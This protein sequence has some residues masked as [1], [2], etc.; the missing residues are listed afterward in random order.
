MNRTIKSALSA[1]ALASVLALQACGSSSGNDGSAGN[2]PPAETPPVEP[3]PVE[4]PPVE[5]P[6]VEPP[7]PEPPAATGLFRSEESTAQFLTRATFGPSEAD[8]QDLTGTEASEW[9]LDQFAAEP[10][11]M[12]P[13]MQQFQ[14][15][16]TI[17]IP[18]AN[19]MN[20]A[21]T[22]FAFWRN[23]LEGEDQLRQRMILA[24]SEILVISAG[25]SDLLRNIPEGTAMHADIL[26]EHA[27]GNY[28]DL[29]EDITYS[30]GMGHFLTYLGNQ[31]GD[32]ATGRVP[33]ENYARELLQLFT[34]GVIELNPDG[35]PVLDAAGNTIELY[36][37]EDITG[38]ARVFTGLDVPPGTLSFL[39]SGYMQP[40]VIF[41]NRHSL[42]EKSFLDFTIPANTS[43]EQ[44]IDMALD[45]IMAHPNVGPFLARQL[46]QRFVTSNPPPE[47]VE[48]VATAFDTGSYSLP[49]GTQVGDGRKG[50]LAAT[51]SA[52]LFDEILLDDDIVNDPTFGKVKE[53]LLRF[54]QWVRAFDVTGI[55]PEVQ[56]SLIYSE[57]P[58][59]LGQ[60]AYRAPSV[61]NFFRPG[62][63]P[64]GTES[65]DLDL[66][67]PELQT[68]N[69]S[70]LTSYAN[71]M[72]GFIFETVRNV[73]VGA[74][75]QFYGFWSYQGT[76]NDLLTS[77]D[78]ELS[79]ELA[80]VDDPEALVDRLDL[81]LT[82]GN[83]SDS[84]RADII[85]R[86]DDFPT[87]GDEDFIALSRVRSAIFLVMMS[88][89]FL[90]Q[91]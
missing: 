57:L 10:S 89:D 42:L 7:A 46:I 49:D 30:P 16:I 27:F 90:V 77:F 91:K 12:T 9:I 73:T 40:M 24:L 29:L 6:P 20:T 35:T 68:T 51:V 63:I 38:L 17:P 39:R 48:R 83:L 87:A 78:A 82:A 19:E 11:L 44:S 59:N 58:M 4:P 85:A 37:N 71:F 60:Q 43:A 8:I 26:A 72:Q 23:V 74:Y 18:I 45:H 50:D 88:P 13:L 79:A 25:A 55:T 64:P 15:N 69:A 53:P 76:P 3:P 33:D 66:T 54:S 36:D 41:P 56:F 1:A 31:R 2:V 84:T 75:A 14:A 52:I 32:P 81:L 80:L 86:L 65:G 5:P 47:Y 28:R 67:V 21:T 61:F 70:T 34:I 62:F 22:T